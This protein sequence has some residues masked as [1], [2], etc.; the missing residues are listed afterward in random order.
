MEVLSISIPTPYTSFPTRLSNNRERSKWC[1]KNEDYTYIYIKDLFSGIAWLCAFSLLAN[2]NSKKYTKL[3]IFSIW[4]R[5]AH[6]I[7]AICDGEKGSYAFW[8]TKMIQKP[9]DLKVVLAEQ[10]FF[11]DTLQAHHLN[12]H[13][14]PQISMT[15]SLTLNVR[16]QS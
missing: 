9:N 7:G 12:P 5:R 3:S 13:M 4:H 1:S 6:N 2:L 8:R 11:L 10:K 15:N 14:A 16:G